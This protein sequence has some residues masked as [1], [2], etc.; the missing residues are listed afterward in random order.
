M[1]IGDIVNVFLE[2]INSIY[3]GIV[4]DQNPRIGNNDP[5]FIVKLPYGHVAY[6]ER[7]LDFKNGEYWERSI[8]A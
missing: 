4:V 2:N 7:D 8:T 6:Y 1:R 3:R 5:L